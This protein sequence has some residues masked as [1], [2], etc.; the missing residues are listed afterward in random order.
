MLIFDN[1][2]RRLL[3]LLILM[4]FALLLLYTN[5]L[6]EINFYQNRILLPEFEVNFETYKLLQESRVLYQNK[7]RT[8]YENNSQKNPTKLSGTTA[9]EIGSENLDNAQLPSLNPPFPDIDLTSIGPVFIEN[10]LIHLFCQYSFDSIRCTVG[11]K[12]PAKKVYFRNTYFTNPSFEAINITF[13]W[14]ELLELFKHRHTNDSTANNV[15]AWV[16]IQSMTS[17]ILS[18]ELFTNYIMLFGASGTNMS[19]FSGKADGEWYI[20]DIDNSGSENSAIASPKQLK[21]RKFIRDQICALFAVIYLKLLNFILFGLAIIFQFLMHLPIYIFSCFKYKDSNLGKSSCQNGEYESGDFE[22]WIE[23]NEQIERLTMQSLNTFK[24]RQDVQYA[25]IYTRPAAAETFSN[26]SGSKHLRLRKTSNDATKVIGQLANISKD[27]L[28]G[29]E[30][31]LEEPSRGSPFSLTSTIN[32]P[33]GLSS[34]GSKQK[35][36]PHNY[37]LKISNSTLV[38]SDVE[39]KQEVPLNSFLV[40]SSLDD[41]VNKYHLLYL[42]VCLC[43]M[44]HFLVYEAVNIFLFNTISGML[45][46]LESSSINHF[47]VSRKSIFDIP[48]FRSSRQGSGQSNLTLNSNGYLFGVLMD[49][50]GCLIN[51][52]LALIFHTAYI[53]CLYRYTISVY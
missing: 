29:V 19:L 17:N 16:D 48:S 49:F 26:N 53:F 7:I 12:I 34:T 24:S 3:V 15:V 51:F 13:G 40:T 23:R 44:F 39:R 38:N 33:S 36:S 31:C 22:E 1:A 10:G 4:L 8:L 37:E 27:D 21:Y 18:I 6:Q 32:S 50:C 30:K 11:G 20:D 46:T 35:V 42:M 5:Y 9:I 28:I 45:S 41:M 25:T 47:D 43:L 14:Y 2:F 52:F